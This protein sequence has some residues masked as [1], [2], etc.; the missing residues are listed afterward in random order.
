MSQ[1]TE[2]LLQ[3]PLYVFDLPQ[4]LLS[5][6]ELKAQNN[7]AISV[8]DEADLIAESSSKRGEN[9]DG[10]SSATSCGLCGLSFPSV[11]E[12]R[13]HVRSDLHGYNMKQ[14]MRGLKVVGENEF[15]KL[16]GDLDESISGSDS[17]DDSASSDDDGRKKDTT[18]SALLKKQANMA[19]A[20][21]DDFTTTKAKV[22]AGKPPLLWFSSSK[23][24]SNVALGV[25]RALLPPAIQVGDAATILQTIKDKQLSPKPPP[26]QP[27][28][29]PTDESGGVPLPRSLQPDTSAA[30]PHYF[31]CMIG[32]GHFAA[33]VVSLT[34]KMT[35]KA[36]VEDRSATVLAHKTFHRYTTR[37]KQ[38]GSQSAN[39][40]AK[41]AAHSA[42]AGIR[43]YNEAALIAEVRQLLHDWKVWIDSSELVFV[44]A[45]G[46]TNRRTLFG[47]YEDQVLTS[48]DQRIRSFPFATRRA[49][50]A[51][52]MRSFVELTRVKVLTIDEAAIARK[53][54]E[55][56]AARQAA[57]AKAAAKPATPKPV[58]PS[59]AE[60]EATLHTTQLQA[61][62]RR[63]K[64]P[65]LVSYIT[66]NNLSPNFTFFPT[67]NPQNHH[68]PTPLHL[69]ASLNAPALISSLLLKAKADPTVKSAEGKTAFEIAGD[70]A[71]RDSFRLA[72]SELGESA[73]DW[74]S[75]GVP[76][77]LSKADY[78]VR[79]QREKDEKAAEDAAEQQ[80]RKTE[81]ERLRNEDKIREEQGK[82]KKFGKG[83][84][85][86]QVLPEKTAQ[87]K[88]EEE[89]RG[90]TPEMRM[91][92]ERERRARAAE[93]RFKAMSGGT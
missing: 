87:E 73:F 84:T 52:L 35:K 11:Q 57:E 43:R 55:E 42:G 85:L 10:P 46:T 18:L 47:P 36:G 93:A 69:A 51:E 17:S 60:E 67:D 32:G 5:T 56:E 41:G 86:A 81:T 29:V 21:L 48:R 23:L 33:M 16:V 65:A 26:T 19:D 1:T 83:K 49:T 50:Q 3:R 22:G 71:T 24:P 9:E 68:A 34:P 28:S 40:S 27:T 72:R 80:R 64:A 45:T 62:I 6:L 7:A 82:E 25:Y 14:K 4:E 58:K 44:R 75:A 13:S 53:A 20:D 91:K 90:M 39:D 59:K 31:L 2:P 38:G 8:P 78:D 63:S 12:Q 92:L 74:D 15:E 77:A 30:G 61:L 88:R 89:A 66:S 70:R 76:T 54:K 79:M 37:R